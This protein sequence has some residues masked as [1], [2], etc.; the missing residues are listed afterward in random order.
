MARTIITWDLI[1]QYQFIIK[2][3]DKET[4]RDKMNLNI[5]RNAERT[6]TY[7]SVLPENLFSLDHRISYISH[8]E[9][10]FNKIFKSLSSR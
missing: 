5:I 4:S 9:N 2:Y 3:V 7:Q 8:H 1:Y 6:D 10:N